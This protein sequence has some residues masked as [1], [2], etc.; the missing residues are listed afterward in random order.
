MPVMLARG[1][2]ENKFVL[3]AAAAWR[4]TLGA[5]VGGAFGPPC[6]P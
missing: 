4:G 1:R 3:G 6:G 2:A 5:G